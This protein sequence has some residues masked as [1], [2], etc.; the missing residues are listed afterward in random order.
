MFADFFILIGSI[1]LSIV[2]FL[3]NLSFDK[4]RIEKNEGGYI[5]TEIF[6]K[7]NIYVEPQTLSKSETGFDHIRD[8]LLKYMV[9]KQIMAL[10]ILLGVILMIFCSFEL[11]GMYF[12]ITIMAYIF[13]LSYP[14]IK[15]QRGYSDLNQEPGFLRKSNSASPQRI[16]FLRWRIG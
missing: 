14:K 7:L 3:K 15:E 9:D 16:P 11:V 6:S 12:V 1:A 4:V 5:D 10:L 13:I 2:D 8:E